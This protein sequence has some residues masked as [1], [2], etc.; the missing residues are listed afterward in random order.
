MISFGGEWAPGKQFEFLTLVRKGNDS[1][2]ARKD[3]IDVEPG[4][5]EDIWWPIANVQEVIDTVQALGVTI[6]TAEAERVRVELE[7]VAAE[8]SRKNAEASRVNAENARI[9]RENSRINAE[10]AR[11][12]A[13]GERA[14]S[15]GQRASAE[16]ERAAAEQGRISNE[17][18]RVSNERERVERLNNYW[19]PMMELFQRAG[20]YNAEAKEYAETL[21]PYWVE[22][23]TED[24]SDLIE[25]WVKHEGFLY[26]WAYGK[27]YLVDRDFENNTLNFF[28]AEGNGPIYVCSPSGWSTRSRRKYRAAAHVNP[29]ALDTEEPAST[30]AVYEAIQNFITRAVNDLENYYLKS[31]TYTKT[32]VN[33]LMDAIKQF[34]YVVASSL[35]A[36]SEETMYKIYLTPSANPDTQNVRD[37]FITIR[38]GSEGSYTYSWEQIGSTAIELSGKQD[39]IADLAAI[40][41]GAAAGATAVQPGA[42][43]N[44]VAKTQPFTN[45]VGPWRPDPCFWKADDGCF[46]VKGTG[47]LNTVLRTRDFVHYKD[48]GRTFLSA[49]AVAWLNEHYGHAATDDAEYLL[50]PHHWAPQVL[51]IGDNWVLYMAIVERTGTK[52]APENGTAHI[53][54]FTSRT[55]YGDFTNPVVIVSDNEVRAAANSNTKW[56]NVIDPFVYCDPDDNKLYLIAGSTYAIRRAQL[57][58]DGLS[59]ANGTYAQHIAGQS[60]NTSPNRETVYE[61]A[62]LYKRIHNGTTYWYLFVSAGHYDQRDYCVMV[63][64]STKASGITSSAAVNYNG[65]EGTSMRNGGATLILSTESNESQFWGPGHIGGIFESADGRTFMLYHCHDGNGTSD[66]KLF[67]QE[68]FWD[69]NGWPYFGNSGHPVESG[70]VSLDIITETTD[71]LNASVPFT[72]EQADWEQADSSAV[73]YIKNKPTI[74]S[75]SGKADKVQS[76]TAGNFAGLDNTGNI[77]DSGKKASDFATAGRV[78]DIEEKIPTQASS[79]NQLADK[80]FVNSTVQYNTANARGNWENQFVL[81]MTATA[82]DYPVDYAGSYKPSQNDYMVLRDA[83]I[84]LSFEAQLNVYLEPGVCFLR[85]SDIYVIDEAE[86]LEIIAS[87]KIAE[88][89][90]YEDVSADTVVLDMTASKDFVYPY[91]GKYYARLVDQMGEETFDITDTTKWCEIN[92]GRASEESTEGTWFFKYSGNW[93]TANIGGWIPMFQVN[94]KPLTAAQVA[95]LNSNITAA[96]TS[97]LQGLPSKP[98]DTAAQ[99]LSDA[100]KLQART[101]IGATAPEV[102]WATYGTTT[103]SDIDAALAAGKIVIARNG[104]KYAFYIDRDTVTV[105]F[106]N[107]GSSGRLETWICRYSNN[108][109]DA[110]VYNAQEK[111]NLVTSFGTTPSDSK[112]PSEKL[113]KDSLDT[114]QP[115]ID[116]SHKL[117]YS[118]LDNTPTIPAAPVNMQGATASAAGS[119]GYAPAPAAG[120]E[121]KFLRGDGT[122]QNVSVPQEIMNLIYAGL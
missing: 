65:K 63:G 97:K 119:A 28:P 48:T 115:L 104:N 85:G 88:M 31:E 122:W 25:E 47:S 8:Q 29:L 42:L 105:K 91:Q 36:A 27:F 6:N 116:S 100:E 75:V 107:V 23:E 121:G 14:Q 56:N 46:Y 41:S 32:E 93:N 24:Y 76:P 13:E 30:A 112:S 95:A 59:L 110:L 55:P 15:E 77:T 90:K 80:A 84:W 89:G 66:R 117:D 103:T 72:Q 111:S 1:F 4:T 57:A 9:T 96:L 34:S 7:R 82:G 39:V 83:S 70:D 61:G 54:A 98:V 33:A 101:N 19:E 94:E 11:I 102:F 12:A 71:I 69:E 10:N 113:V 20:E 38:S 114:K 87:H 2:I 78:A 22:L 45:P 67:I 18:E 21:A 86:E 73:D 44:Y 17:Q 43:A 58:D 50:K 108:A 118:L 5:N 52:A 3:N 26:S 40:R 68:L 62:Y 49:S 64:R 16:S 99:V 53:V 81:P 92:D 51:K 120:D 109:W 37:E 74:P 106:M 35:P 60:I 79:S